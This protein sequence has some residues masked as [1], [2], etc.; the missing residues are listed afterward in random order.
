MLRKIKCKTGFCEDRLAMLVGLNITNRLMQ[1]LKM[2]KALLLEVSE[3][4]L[5]N[6]IFHRHELF[7]VN[8]LKHSV[9]NQFYRF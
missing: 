1:S 9:R 8:D 3:I 6:H 4:T 7:H 2:T 5:T